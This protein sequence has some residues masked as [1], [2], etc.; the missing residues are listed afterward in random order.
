MEVDT[1]RKRPIDAIGRAIVIYELHSNVIVH[2]ILP[3]PL[4]L[5]HRRV[6]SELIDDANRRAW[7]ERSQKNHLSRWPHL[8]EDGKK[9]SSR[10]MGDANNGR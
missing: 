3:D 2:R 6:S 8:R 10:R 7:D 5:E 1:S 9:H 4:R